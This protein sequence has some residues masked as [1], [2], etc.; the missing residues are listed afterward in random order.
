MF[1]CLFQ[2]HRQ[3]KN[4]FA[5]LQLCLKSSNELNIST[6]KMSKYV[7]CAVIQVNITQK[8]KQLFFDGFDDGP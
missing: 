3:K 8:F 7:M 5:M 4:F 6:G 2:F 1:V